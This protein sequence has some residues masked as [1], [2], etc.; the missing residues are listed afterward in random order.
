MSLRTVRSLAMLALVV[1]MAGPGR[2][3]LWDS[4][5]LA[6][7]AAGL[8]DVGRDLFWAGFKEP[9]LP[10]A[11]TRPESV[12]VTYAPEQL[13]LPK[14]PLPKP[15]RLDPEPAQT[16]PLVICLLVPALLSL[17]LMYLFR[18]RLGAIRIELRWPAR[19]SPRRAG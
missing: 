19:G 13:E 12:N 11:Y 15:H 4:D 6:A 5:T 16:V 14:N 1:A 8:R 9:P 17:A 18:K 10:E 3:C 7:E 2:A